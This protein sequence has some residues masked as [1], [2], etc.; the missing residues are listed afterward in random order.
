MENNNLENIINTITKK[1]F[2]KIKIQI[3]GPL[4]TDDKTILYN[5]IIKYKKYGV[6][7]YPADFE[8][9]YNKLINLY[10]KLRTIFNIIDEQTMKN[11]NIRALNIRSIKY[12]NDKEALFN[13][14]TDKNG[15]N[16]YE[17]FINHYEDQ[18]KHNERLIFREERRKRNKI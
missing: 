18:N 6:I 3:G 5:K 7:N 4:F 17:S 2:Q 8:N 10:D 16:E 11:I 14:F 15:I 13:T 1:D 12:N 9:I